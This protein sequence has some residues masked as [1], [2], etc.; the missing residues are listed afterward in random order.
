[1]LFY[2]IVSS[3]AASLTGLLIYIYFSK[4]G[5]FEDQEAVKYQMFHEEKDHQ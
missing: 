1:M 5:Q 2:T 3:L 4:K